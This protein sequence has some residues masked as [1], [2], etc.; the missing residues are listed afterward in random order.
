[1]ACGLLL[2]LDG[3]L[4][5]SLA[6]LRAV[7]DDFLASFGIAGSDEGFAALNGP[8]LAE[9]V[10]RLRVRHGLPG[11]PAELLALYRRLVDAAHGVAP[12][13]A[14]AE[15]LLRQARAGGWRIAVVTSSPRA[16][17]L[18]WLARQGLAP[19]VDAV[20]GG[21]EVAAGKPAPLPYR[22]GLERLGCAAAQSL[23]V[24]DS[25]QGATAATGAGIETLAIAAPGDR[26]GWPEGVRF[27]A[28][29]AET[30]AFLQPCP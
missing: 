1:M 5:D 13:A 25:R 17:A 6:A 11:T 8:P 18:G 4:A 20:V 21:D 14:G 10:A 9:V 12:P 19:L 22:L 3:T 27:I 24:E 30:A 7:Y 28:R 29:L 26:T 23:A 2:D 15:A 16:A